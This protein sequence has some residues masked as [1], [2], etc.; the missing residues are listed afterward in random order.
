MM[1]AQ[2]NS[3][4]YK[5]LTGVSM[6]AVE[7]LQ[8]DGETAHVARSLRV[9]P[10]ARPILTFHKRVLD[11]YQLRS[12]QRDAGLCSLWRALEGESG[13]AGVRR[14]G[15]VTCELGKLGW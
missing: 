14:E 12:V 8:P 5:N 15:L 3:M 4:A 6:S 10:A 1:A 2:Q 9:R 11:E 7:S 13:L